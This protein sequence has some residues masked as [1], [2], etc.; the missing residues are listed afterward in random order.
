MHETP[1]FFG[2]SDGTDYPVWRLGPP[3]QADA[4]SEPSG[5]DLLRRVVDDVE[6]RRRPRIGWNGKASNFLEIED[7]RA[8][9][10]VD[11][12]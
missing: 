3:D 5:R 11:R 1:Y 6:R 2:L 10:L 7:I 12:R 8:R 4:S 9:T